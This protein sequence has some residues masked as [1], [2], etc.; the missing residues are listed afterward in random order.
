MLQEEVGG[1]PNNSWSSRSV[2]RPTMGRSLR[3][4]R[5][6]EDEKGYKPFLIHSSRGNNFPE[7]ATGG[8]DDEEEGKE[9][10]PSSYLPRRW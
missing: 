3:S 9:D 10:S 7:Q 1:D 4:G 8:E 5:T 6:E 2:L